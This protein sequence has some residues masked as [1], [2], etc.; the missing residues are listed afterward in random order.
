MNDSKRLTYLSLLIICT[1]FSCKPNPK[2]AAIEFKRTDN[3]VVLRLEN[4]VDQLFPL[5]GRSAYDS[6]VYGQIYN[7]LAGYDP[8]TKK[9]VPELLKEIPKAKETTD[10]SGQQ[11]ISYEFEILEQ[12]VWADGSPVTAYDYLVSMKALLNPLVD[13]GRLRAIIYDEVAEIIV[14]A[15]NTKKFTVVCQ[16]PSYLTLDNITN[17]IPILPAY[18]LDPQGLS[19]TINFADLIDPDKADELANSDQ[20]L[21]EIAL[22]INSTEFTKSIDNITGS[23]PYTLKEWQTGLNIT[24]QKKTN[25]WGDKISKE[26]HPT[27]S[28]F[29]NQLQYKPITNEATALAAI[30]LQEIDALSR[31]NTNEFNALKEN[32]AVNQYYDFKTTTALV[33]YYLTLNTS[34]PKLADKRVRQALA[35][36]LD[37][38]E[39][40]ATVYAGLGERVANPIHPDQPYYNQELPIIKTDLPKARNLLKDAGWLDTNNNGIVDKM[41]DGERVELTLDHLIVG[42]RETTLN[43]TLLF[44]DQAKRAGIDIN[45]VAV[46][47]GVFASKR[48]SKDFE[49][50]SGGSTISPNWNPRQRWYSNGAG[51]YSNFGT[52][53][54]D[55]MIDQI[56]TTL[57]A[58]ERDQLYKKLQSV[59]HEE[60]ALLLLWIPKIPV[61]I[62]KRFEYELFSDSPYYEPRDFKLKE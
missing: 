45:I 38:D 36:A 9:F 46:E 14:D 39:V 23:G 50:M 61:I 57:S 6:Q 4:D 27:L 28:A 44:K 51:N 43:S 29:P 60:Q 10:P 54:T 7:Y 1:F 32:P 41:I 56:L 3:T 37:V 18:I 2:T 12:A 16:Q 48:E 52:A 31:P 47:P 15:G 21:Q 13:A 17:I 24:L 40:L 55:A 26:T 8:I 20:N 19:K 22:R 25:W 53:E 33:S 49:V 34:T 5:L 59:I 30:R 42:G 62:S 11:K 58:P 35:Y